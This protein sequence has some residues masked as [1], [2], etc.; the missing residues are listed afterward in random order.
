MK[1]LYNSLLDVAEYRSEY[2]AI[3]YI[4]KY[5][6]NNNS[7]FSL[8]MRMNY[9]SNIIKKEYSSKSDIWFVGCFLYELLTEE[10]LF[11]ID[12]DSIEK[13][14]RD[15]EHLKQM[16]QYLGI[17]PRTMIQNH[18]LNEEVIDFNR[19][20]KNFIG[21]HRF[22]LDFKYFHRI[23]I[24]SADGSH[25]GRRILRAGAYFHAET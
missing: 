21:F 17:L 7:S 4:S 5:V 14:K 18:K 15:K 11:D 23:A 8:E 24:L 2:E 10:I 12:V 16:H 9:C 22:S 13:S 19:F 20:P 6:N 25:D 3:K 1:I